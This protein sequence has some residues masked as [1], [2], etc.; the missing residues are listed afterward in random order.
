M[1]YVDYKTEELLPLVAKLAFKY[2]S[3]ESSSVT[4]ETANM[5]MEAVC[6]CIR[7]NEREDA[8]EAE[9]DSES[10]EESKAVTDSGS[11]E[12]SKDVTGSESTKKLGAAETAG[13]KVPAAR[14]RQ[15]TASESYRQGYEKVLAKTRHAQDVYNEL[16][17]DFRSFGNM[18]YQDTVL[19]AL[20]AF[21]MKYDPK[22][23]PQETIIGLDYPTL[24]GIAEDTGINA[25]ERYLQFIVLEQRF[26]RE[27]SGEMVEKLLAR[28]SGD[29]RIDFF[30]LCSVVLRHVLA[31][32]LLGRQP[33]EMLSGEEYAALGRICTGRS[34][35]EL[36]ALLKRL[37]EKLAASGW[38]EDAELLWYLQGDCEN[39]AVE[40]AE[41]AKRNTLEQ[42]VV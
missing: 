5:L 40:L 15:M 12:E 16:I 9:A 6:Y 38:K 7:E 33:G 3:G 17:A 42:V 41:G 31:A 36:T 19:K 37:T 18:N 27:F 2:T 24:R 4:Y 26:L 21:F 39:F 13:R 29:Y 10:T 8:G 25:V 35:D 28:F 22:F 14:G 34:K 1:K 20:P 11:T 32:G 30:N 23:A